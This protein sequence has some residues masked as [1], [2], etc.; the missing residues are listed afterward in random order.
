MQQANMRVCPVNHF[1]IHF[2]NKAQNA[3]CSGMLGTK[4]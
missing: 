4:I 1:P 3:M 2:Q